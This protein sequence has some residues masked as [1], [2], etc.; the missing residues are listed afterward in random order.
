MNY[1]RKFS[2]LQDLT[3]KYKT[4]VT[5]CKHVNVPMFDRSHCQSKPTSA[6]DIATRQIS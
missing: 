3:N 5:R 2:R 4:S 1:R 6:A